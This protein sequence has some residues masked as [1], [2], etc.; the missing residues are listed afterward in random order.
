MIMVF[1]C[2][3]PHT[4]VFIHLCFW[5]G[6]GC[7]ALCILAQDTETTFPWSLIGARGG[8][9]TEGGHTRVTYFAEA[10]VFL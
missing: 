10:G 6:F 5:Q 3:Q 9:G 4:F 2:S 7:I 8:G 1:D